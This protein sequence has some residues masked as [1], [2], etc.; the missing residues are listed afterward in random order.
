MARLT[1]G[2]LVSTPLLPVGRP[3][4]GRRDMLSWKVRRAGCL[5]R[6]LVIAVERAPDS[7]LPLLLKSYADFLRSERSRIADPSIADEEILVHFDLALSRTAQPRKV[8]Q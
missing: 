5:L 3:S 2:P 7:S 8:V 6:R 4:Q 1:F